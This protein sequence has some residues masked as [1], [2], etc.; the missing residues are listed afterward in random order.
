MESLLCYLY[1]IIWVA[2]DVPQTEN[3]HLPIIFGWINSFPDSKKKVD[4]TFYAYLL[5]F[6]RVTRKKLN[7]D[8]LIV[9]MVFAFFADAIPVITHIHAPNFL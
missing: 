3:R 9:P 8:K 2:T 6:Y 7:F 5:Y 1:L 4:R